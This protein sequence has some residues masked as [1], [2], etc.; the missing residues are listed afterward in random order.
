MS[1]SELIL[2]WDKNNNLLFFPEYFY[3]LMTKDIP[4]EMVHRRE[5]VSYL[6][7]LSKIL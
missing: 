4:D 5:Y 3:V 6:E 1:L 2:S 7:N